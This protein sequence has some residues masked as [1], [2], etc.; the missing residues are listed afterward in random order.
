MAVT[1]PIHLQ[2]VPKGKWLPP[3]LAH[4]IRAYHPQTELGKVVKAC[5]G[6][7]SAEQA[8]DLL[9]AITRSVVIE[10]ALSA[11]VI[12]HPD[13]PLAGGWRPMDPDGMERLYTLHALRHEALTEG[14]FVL[15]DRLMPRIARLSH[16]AGLVEEHGVVSRRVVT[17]A[18]VQFLVDAWQNLVEMEIMKYHALG[19][20]TT[21][22]AASQ[23]ALVTELSTAYNP[24]NT[25]ATGSLTEGASANIFRSVGTNTLDGSAAVTEHGLLSQAATGGGVLWDRSVFSVLNLAASDSLQTTYDLS[26]ASGG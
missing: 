3:S 24:D 21:A 16:Q 11:T 2:I 12:R 8:G 10:T 17:D 6:T 26:A 23:T 9:D 18:G 13:S 25:R 20:G 4:R 22:E 5:L 14:D 7:L 15:A 1:H 19:T